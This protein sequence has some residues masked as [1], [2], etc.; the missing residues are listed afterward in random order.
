[1]KKH[2]YSFIELLCTLIIVLLIF[3]CVIVP[4]IQN[5]TSKFNK[6]ADILT[7]KN[8]YD[9]L[10]Y[11]FVLDSIAY[12]DKDMY[13]TL[14][15]KDNINSSLDKG[16]KYNVISYLENSLST[17]PTKTRLNKENYVV[18]LSTDGTI[19]ILSGTQF[20]DKIY[21]NGKGAY[22]Q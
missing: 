16:Y 10:S 4:G 22:V 21:P 15:D 8:I 7:A 18:H 19:E 5:V 12:P 9:S 20:G 14:G 6:T 11:G 13:I 2:S 3:S 17:Y 1:M